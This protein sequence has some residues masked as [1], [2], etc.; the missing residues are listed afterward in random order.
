MHAEPHAPTKTIHAV[1][2]DVDGTYADYGVVPQAHAHAVR[3]ARAAG[4]KVLLCTGRPL[5]MLPAHILE[6]GFD[7]L[8]ASAGAYVEVDGEV[9][10]DRRFPA[11]MAAR[12]LAALDAHDAVYVL[13]TPEALHVRRE[14]EP[15]LRE[16]IEAHFS[17]RPD[18]RASGSSA[19]LGSMAPIPEHP[20]FAKISVFEA[21]VSVGSIAA[22]I[23]QDVAVVENSIADEGRHTGEL[24]RRGISKADGVAVAIDYLGIDRADTIAFGDGENDL[25][26]VAYAGLGVAI[27]GSH[28]G[29]LELADR[30]APP[31]SRDGIAA[32]FAELG[33]I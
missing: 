21:P 13:E 32:A 2:L 8:V 11:E 16:I 23:G 3:A 7:G 6:A 9:L 24:F 31:P 12:T 5:A 1:F 28:P 26:M 29:L 30:T 14:A 27:E 19:I 25:E 33:L 10:M 4:H 17:Q 20:S 15:R 18:A 22:E